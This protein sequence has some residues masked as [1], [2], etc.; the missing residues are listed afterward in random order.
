MK[1]FWAG[2]IL[3]V[4]IL[5]VSIL[6]VSILVLIYPVYPVNPV[7]IFFSLDGIYRPALVRHSLDKPLVGFHILMRFKRDMGHTAGWARDLH[8][9]FPFVL[10]VLT[11]S[12]LSCL[13]FFL[14]T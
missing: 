14:T 13:T 9:Y 8:D 11:P 5:V 4:S 6:V 3:V 10:F 1:T 2:F 12:C 7:S